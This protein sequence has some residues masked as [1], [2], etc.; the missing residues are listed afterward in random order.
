MTPISASTALALAAA[1]LA[2]LPS[3]RADDTDALL[4]QLLARTREIENS[5]T[6]AQP[7]NTETS[8]VALKS[9]FDTLRAQTAALDALSGVTETESALS[10]NPSAQTT[11]AAPRVTSGTLESGSLQPSGGLN[12]VHLSGYPALPNV[13][14]TSSILNPT[15]AQLR[16]DREIDEAMEKRKLFFQQNPAPGR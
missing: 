12:G 4:R 8:D 16:H 6:A 5:G 11:P 14:P 7:E 1:L 10:T 9:L 2:P 3:A 15:A 13:E